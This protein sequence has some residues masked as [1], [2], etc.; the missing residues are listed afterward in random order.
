MGILLS[1][2][3]IMLTSACGAGA[4][5][6]PDEKEWCLRNAERVESAADDLGV[7]GFIGAYYETQGDGLGSDGRPVTTERNIAVTEGL[8]SRNAVDPEAVLYDLFSRY[9][10]HPDG[11][12]ACNAAS[13]GNV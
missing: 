12:I 8:R 9:L 5:L 11:Q 3:L 4:S 10:R 7:L 13:A 6:S 2:A 1:A